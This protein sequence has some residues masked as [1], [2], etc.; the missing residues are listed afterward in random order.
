MPQ[1]RRRTVRGPLVRF[2]QDGVGWG[3]SRLCLKRQECRVIPPLVT[4]KLAVFGV[5]SLIENR[6][7]HVVKIPS[8]HEHDID[9]SGFSLERGL[10][11]GKELPL[12]KAS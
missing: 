3:K 5:L 10:K 6:V 11:E 8:V 7:V 2:L 4:P 1:D 9:I 12:A